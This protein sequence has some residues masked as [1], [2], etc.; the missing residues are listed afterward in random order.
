M[1]SCTRGVS[2]RGGGRLASCTK[3]ERTRGG[4]RLSAQLRGAT[5]VL[6]QGGRACMVTVQSCKHD[7]RGGLRCPPT[8]STTQ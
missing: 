4:G 2:T 1:A 7:M 8:H 3:G 5:R 6:G